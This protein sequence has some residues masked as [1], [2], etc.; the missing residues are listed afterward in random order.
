MRVLTISECEQWLKERNF[1]QM[2]TL[3]NRLIHR[4]H[5][6]QTVVKDE[7]GLRVAVG[8]RLGNILCEHSGGLFVV[9]DHGVWPS[10][11]LPDAF[12]AY[13]QQLGELR[14]IDDAPAHL[15]NSTD[16]KEAEN[17]L[18]MAHLFFWDGLIVEGSGAFSAFFSHDEYLSISAESPSEL[19]ALCDD[20]RRFG[21]FEQAGGS[22]P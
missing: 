12:L 7:V 8:R 10:C 20:L 14:S 22:R 17:I 4:K 18:A 3:L 13:R 16:I 15:L 5:S 2:S 21:L 1:G 19:K 9:T 6:T 11:E